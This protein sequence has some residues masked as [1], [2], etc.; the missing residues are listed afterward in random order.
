VPPNFIS[1]NQDFSSWNW[2][3]M[4]GSH[5]Q[6]FQDC[7]PSA[8]HIFPGK[9]QHIFLRPWGEMPFRVALN[10]LPIS[11]WQKCVGRVVIWKWAAD[12]CVVGAVIPTLAAFLGEKFFKAHAWEARAF[13]FCF[14][15]SSPRW[16]SHRTLQFR[17]QWSIRWNTGNDLSSLFQTDCGIISTHI[18]TI[19]M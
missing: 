1:Q 8:W 9:T 19:K 14:L 17:I 10:Y 11:S 18:C 12:S 7:F 5:F 6:Y 3:R 16:M 15:C 4:F 13:L 2:L